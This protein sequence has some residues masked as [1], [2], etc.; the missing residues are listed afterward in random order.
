MPEGTT[1]ADMIDEVRREL[2]YR[3][4][5]YPRLVQDRK[6]NPREADRRI[7]VMQGVLAFLQGEASREATG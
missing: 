3:K 5:V 2:S 1:F 6:M 4:F 7:E